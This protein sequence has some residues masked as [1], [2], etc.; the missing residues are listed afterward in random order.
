[1]A[2]F[3]MAL[4]YVLKHEGGWADDPD[5]PGGATNFG[6]TLAVARKHGVPDK[7]ALRAISQEKV[8]AIYRAGYWQFDGIQDQRVATKI[9]DMAVNMGPATAVTLAQRSVN[10][11]GGSVRVDGDYGLQTEGGIN[12]VL[13][14]ALLD[15]LCQASAQRYHRIVDLRPS[16]AKFLRGWLKRAASIPSAAKVC[17]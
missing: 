14:D 5:D 1:M 7:A 9:F 8:A 4:P 11:V 17:K 2:C 6:I 16:S 3:L 13:P 12:F 10:E 15:A